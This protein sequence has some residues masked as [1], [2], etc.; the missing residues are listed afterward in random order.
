MGL[1]RVL[2]LDYLDHPDMDAGAHLKWGK[3]S[4]PRIAPTAGVWR[5]G[6]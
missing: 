4:P 1:L 6:C 2:Y 5:N 3:V